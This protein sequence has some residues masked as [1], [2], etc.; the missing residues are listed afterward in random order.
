MNKRILLLSSLFFIIGIFLTNCTPKPQP[1]NFGVDQCDNCS[2]NLTDPK[3]ACE[4]VT[5][6]NKSFKYDD[7]EC[8]AYAYL[9]ETKFKETRV[10]L[11]LV[12][13]FMNPGEL[14]DAQKAYYTK[15]STLR[16]PMAMSVGAFKSIDEI[17]KLK[18]PVASPIMDWKGVLVEV[19][20]EMF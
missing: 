18:D 1:I 4:I 2:M 12:E 3:W 5:D 17:Q 19:T 9:K 15:I 8:M 10:V 13:N 16:S 11:I 7:V 20:K 6:K 14:I